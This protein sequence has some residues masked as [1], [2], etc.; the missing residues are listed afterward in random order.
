MMGG[1]VLSVIIATITVVNCLVVGLPCAYCIAR[2][3]FRGKELLLNFLSLPMLIPEVV[4]GISL[5]M[6]F[7]RALLYD[8]LTKILLA[9]FLFTFPYML[10]ALTATLVGYDKSAEE[11]ALVLGANQIQA[12][13]SVVFPLIRAG[14]IGGSIFAFFISFDNTAVT[15]FL[16]DPFTR[17]LPVAL[18]VRLKSYSDPVI[19][20][21]STLLIA[22]SYLII[23]LLEKTVGLDK[24]TGIAPLPGR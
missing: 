14:V 20:A 18:F 16:A 9:H 3:Q 13:A 21:A 5:L 6:F 11:A 17:T 1:L 22:L 2:R 19:A 10:R 15:L 7:T 12:F 24:F 23:I 4:I 8:S